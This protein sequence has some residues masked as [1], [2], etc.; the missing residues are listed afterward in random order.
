MTL[1]FWQE[2]AKKYGYNSNAVNFDPVLDDLEGHFLNKLIKDGDAVCDL[3]CGSGRTIIGIAQKKKNS[4]FYGVDFSRNMIEVA[5]K[6]KKKIK[7]KN[8]HFFNMD[9]TD[10]M[11]ARSFDIKFD[12]IITKRLLINVKGSVKVKVMNNVNSLLS[13]KGTYI[14]TECFSEPLK[15]IN[16]IRHLLDLP[17]IKTNLFNEYLTAD[18][19]KKV[20]RLFYV[21]EK[22]DFGSLYYF[23]SRVYNAYLS[24]GKPDY[25][26]PINTLSTFLAKNG[27]SPIEG[28]SPEVIY[29][30]K[31]R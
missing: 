6:E 21:K 23:I 5:N 30:M 31:K 1:N 11:I 12:K 18:F 22:I 24:K 25:Y 17:E 20:K 14:M 28:Y 9:A 7:L 2:Q 29:L 19:F 10:K 8:V 27:I 13:E 4:E 26:A 15:K 16:E 3:G